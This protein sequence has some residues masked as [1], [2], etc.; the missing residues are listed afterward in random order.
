LL[1]TWEWPVSLENGRDGLTWDQALTLTK[2]TFPI[3]DT[4]HKLQLLISN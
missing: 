3:I 2:Q 1:A 4:T